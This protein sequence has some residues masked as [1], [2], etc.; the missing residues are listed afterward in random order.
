MAEALKHTYPGEEFDCVIVGR[1]LSVSRDAN[2]PP[3]LRV[4]GVEEFAQLAIRLRMAFEFVENIG[5]SLE[6]PMRV[7]QALEYHG[8][9][10]PACVSNQA[11]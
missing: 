1:P 8:L 9:L 7:Q 11:E 5:P 2:P 4:I 6:H 3:T 10:W